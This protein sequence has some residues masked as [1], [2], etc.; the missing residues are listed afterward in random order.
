MSREANSVPISVETLIRPSV[1]VTGSMSTRNRRTAGSRQS[2]A[3]R[4]RPS[5][6]RSHGT[7][8]SSC[9]TVAMTIEPA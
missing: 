1:S 4:R 5:S 7:G 8:R 2:K 3:S 9:T 6:P